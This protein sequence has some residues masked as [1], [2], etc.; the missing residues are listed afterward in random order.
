[1]SRLGEVEAHTRV[2]L[3]ELLH[4]FGFMS[5]EVIQYDMRSLWP[6]GPDHSCAEVI[7]G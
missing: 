3:Q 2:V 6:I 7:P 4:G 5:R 1:M